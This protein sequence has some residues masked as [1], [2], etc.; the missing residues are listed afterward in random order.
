MCRYVNLVP[1]ELPGVY[2]ANGSLCCTINYEEDNAGK[3]SYFPIARTQNVYSYLSVCSKVYIL[4][5]NTKSRAFQFRW[6]GHDLRAGSALHLMCVYC[7]VS[8]A[9]WC[10]SVLPQHIITIDGGRYQIYTK[11][12]TV[13]TKFL[14]VFFIF[15]FTLSMWPMFSPFSPYFCASVRAIS[16]FLVASGTNSNTLD[17]VLV[18]LP[19]FFYFT[20]FTLVVV[21][22]WVLSFFSGAD[23]C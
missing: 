16:F 8:V 9:R 5:G 11:K 6:W 7:P 22:W 21:V 13:Y 4:V 23:A 18:V 3:R 17:Y 14:L 20:A 10:G 15:L 2:L 12:R 19:T 1:Y